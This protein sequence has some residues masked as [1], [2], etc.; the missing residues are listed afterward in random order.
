MT[1]PHSRR[2]RERSGRWFPG[3]DPLGPSGQGQGAGPDDGDAA[4]LPGMGGP[5]GAPTTLPIMSVSDGARGKPSA[6]NAVDISPIS[7]PRGMSG[8]PGGALDGRPSFDGGPYDSYDPVDEPTNGGPDWGAPAQRPLTP[9]GGERVAGGMPAGLAVGPPTPPGGA[10]GDLVEQLAT[11]ARRVD[12]L[13]R[14]RR[15]DVE[16]VDRLHEENTRLRQGE[17]TEAMAPLLRGL[18]RL[19]DQMSSLGA[20]DPQSVA[21]ILRKQLLQ[22][23]DIAADVRPYIAV[24]GSQFDPTR[25]L[26]LR[27][28]GTDE[29]ARDRTVAR[30]VR[31]GFVRGTSTVLRPAEA[32]VYRHR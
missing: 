29:P 8:R 19:H 28:I 15:H 11:L 25:H 16:M 17:L 3:P 18:I 30:G 26:A 13:A 4:G 5:G 32:E 12:E 21:G 10:A 24:P 2:R 20:D 23:L 9:P 1:E 14:L 27:G 31:P 6:A 22:V 7:N